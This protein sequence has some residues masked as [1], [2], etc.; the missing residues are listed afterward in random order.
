MMNDFTSSISG[1]N[2]PSFANVYG[3]FYKEYNVK[4]YYFDLL[5][6]EVRY[7]FVLMSTIF[8][9]YLTVKIIVLYIILYLLN[10]VCIK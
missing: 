8:N 10:R 4:Y 6:L 1:L 2:K 5:K 3:L 7:L 9:N